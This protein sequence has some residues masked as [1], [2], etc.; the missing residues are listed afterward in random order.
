MR[1]D[2]PQGGSPLNVACLACTSTCKPASGK[3]KVNPSSAIR[4]RS[5]VSAIAE[6][7]NVACLP[8]GARPCKRGALPALH[9]QAKPNIGTVTSAG[10]AL[11]VQLS[12]A[13]ATSSVANCPG[14]VPRPSSHDEIPKLSVPSPTKSSAVAQAVA[15][16]DAPTGVREARI[17]ATMPSATG[18]LT[19]NASSRPAAN[20]GRAKGQIK[21]SGKC[22][23]EIRGHKR[24]PPITKKSKRAPAKAARPASALR[25]A[26]DLTRPTLTGALRHR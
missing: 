18:M 16:Q 10:G 2:R 17:L 24:N 22:W 8:I 4:L 26:T 12:R 1:R 5:S 20:N 6:A 25:R 21:D 23:P 14:E 19:R 7:S 11:S 15:C 9:T 13:E 3:A